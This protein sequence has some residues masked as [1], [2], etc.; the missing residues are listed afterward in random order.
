[1]LKIKRKFLSVRAIKEWNSPTPAAE[2]LFVWDYPEQRTGLEG[3][4]CHFQPYKPIIVTT[5]RCL[6]TQIMPGNGIYQN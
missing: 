3:L 1:M 6:I 4:Q 5:A 2:W